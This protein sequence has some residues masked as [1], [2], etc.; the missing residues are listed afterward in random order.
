MD[1]DSFKG[2]ITR[3][4]N[5]L[6]DFALIGAQSTKQ[7]EIPAAADTLGNTIERLNEFVNQLRNRLDPVLKGQQPETEQSVPLRPTETKMGAALY[8]ANARLEKIEIQI[9]DL[10]N[11][12]AL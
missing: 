9:T 11:R 8:D 10:I 6:P 4:G 12:V 1:Y 3:G 7:N 5:A 2:N